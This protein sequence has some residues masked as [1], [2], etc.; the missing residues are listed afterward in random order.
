MTL[1]SRLSHPLPRFQLDPDTS[2]L[3]VR[4]QVDPSFRGDE[5]RSADWRGDDFIVE[6]VP[7]KRR[8]GGA[9]ASGPGQVLSGIGSTAASI[10][11]R[12]GALGIFSRSAE[13]T[14]QTRSPKLGSDRDETERA[15]SVP[16]RDTEKIASTGPPR[17][18]AAQAGPS[19][20]GPSSGHAVPAQTGVSD[21]ASSSETDDSDSDDEPSAYRPVRIVR[22]K[23]GWRETFPAEA[24]RASPDKSFG[25]T[26]WSS[27]PKELRK[28]R[29]RRWEV[30]PVQIRS[31]PP[32]DFPVPSPAGPRGEPGPPR[33]ATGSVP[34]SASDAHA[35]NSADSHYPSGGY[36]M[37]DYFGIGSHDT[38]AATSPDRSRS[39]SRRVSH[40]HN[41]PTSAVSVEGTSPIDARRWSAT[42]AATGAYA[43]AAASHLSGLISSRL[44]LAAGGGHSE[45]E[46]V[47]SEG[48]ELPQER[49]QGTGT[50]TGS[51]VSASGS[52]RATAEPRA[53][54]DGEHEHEW[55]DARMVSSREL[56]RIGRERQSSS[57]ASA[58]STAS[59]GGGGA[60]EGENS[61]A[62]E[63]AVASAPGSEQEA[64]GSNQ[65]GEASLPPMP[66][67]DQRAPQTGQ[68]EEAALPAAPEP[69]VDASSAS[70]P[71]NA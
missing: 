62:R 64:T 23:P 30:I 34:R 31:L 16:A 46:L 26:R 20:V 19:Q 57:S 17:P 56:D 66:A 32:P 69:A 71:E 53:G 13:S 61:A 35:P 68:G 29:R 55:D 59:E 38:S 33:S 40:D 51:S 5:S 21:P 41:A 8:S 7:R 70:K 3:H 10:G 52:S 4:F 25:V 45:G 28:W 14:P 12:L 67:P 15:P 39:R 11:E 54:R 24:L 63:T 48:I 2:T 18:A 1:P 65:N 50:G 22:L 60:S 58:S 47:H 37:A 49:E 43:S 27:S 9:W 42:A 6:A 44:A 36:A